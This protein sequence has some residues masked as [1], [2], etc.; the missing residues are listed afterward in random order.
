MIV[1]IDKGYTIEIDRFEAETMFKLLN[2]ISRHKAR[3]MG[4]DEQQENC[5]QDW[6]TAFDN[7]LSP[8]VED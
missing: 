1:I 5:I 3:E 6:F 4:L 2:Q 8:S 7:V